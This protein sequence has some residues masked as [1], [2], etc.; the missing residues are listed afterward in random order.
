MAHMM[1]KDTMIGG[2]GSAAERDAE[3]ED[4]SAVERA[5]KAAEAGLFVVVRARAGRLA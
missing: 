5:L 2:T 4:T 3:Y 1:A